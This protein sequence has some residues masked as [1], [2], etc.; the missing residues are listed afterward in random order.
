MKNWWHRICCL[1]LV[2]AMMVSFLPLNALAEQ[3]Q[4]DDSSVST[5]LDVTEPETHQYESYEK[6]KIVNEHIDGRTEFSKEFLLDSGISMSVVYGSPVHYEKDGKWEEIDNTLK[7]NSNNTINNTAG[8][9][10]VR[11]PQRISSTN[12]IQINKD[13]YTLSFGMAG[14]LRKQG[15]L[16]VMSIEPIFDG[17]TTETES[18]SNSDNTEEPFETTESVENITDTEPL[19]EGT[20]DGEETYLATGFDE[21]PSSEVVLAEDNLNMTSMTDALEETIS[22]I[23]E[24]TTAP[25]VTAFQ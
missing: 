22:E 13:G 5:S 8:V 6:S 12:Q 9:W 10:D 17:Q 23:T 24:D 11:F 3:N 20:P 19:E 21:P 1:V 16:E 7:V 2:I 18:A 4:G 14:E 15:N 25:E